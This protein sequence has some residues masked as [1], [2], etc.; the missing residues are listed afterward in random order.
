M[1]LESIAGWT[2]DRDF[3]SRLLFPVMIILGYG[4]FCTT[5]NYREI[6]R[7]FIVFYTYCIFIYNSNEFSISVL[8]HVQYIVQYVAIGKVLAPNATDVWNQTCWLIQAEN[9]M[10]SL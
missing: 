10:C 5:N 2:L 8:S 7:N 3:V 4:A 9:K 6:T 1:N